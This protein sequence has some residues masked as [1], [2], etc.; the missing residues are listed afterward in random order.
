[1]KL[2]STLVGIA[3]EYLVAAELTLRGHI[4]SVTLRNSRGIDILVS[5]ADGNRSAS[6]QVK[7]NSSG[8]PNWV[9]NK[10]SQSFVSPSHF[11]VFVAL[12]KLGVR[13]AFHVVPSEDVAE[14]TRT[15]HQKWLSEPRRDGQPRKDTPMRVFRDLERNYAE[16]WDLLGL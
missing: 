11:Y 10:K 12:E 14:F 13:P 15:F 16:R 8:S 5:S 6:I 4:A 9:L 2:E 7:T 3:G 1:V